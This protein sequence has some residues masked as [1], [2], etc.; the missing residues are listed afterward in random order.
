MVVDGTGFTS[1]QTFNW[2]ATQSHTISVDSIATGA[3]GTRHPYGSWSDG[4]ARSH[5][6]TPLTDSSF[7]AAMS[8]QYLL[9]MNAGT[10]GTVGP[11]N[12][13]FNAGQ[14]VQVSATPSA[15]YSFDAWT[16][17]GSGSFSGGTN[18][19]NVT[20]NAPVTETAAFTA[21][22]IVYTVTTNPA[23][24]DIIVDGVASTSPQAFNWTAAESHT[25]SVDSIQDGSAGTRYAYLSWSNAGTRTQ[26]ISPLAGG[27]LTASFRS[28]YFLT[29]A[30]N[31]GGTA[32]PSSNWQD[33][34]QVVQIT[35]IPN[36]GFIFSG[37]SG[38]GTGAF[39]GGT[40]PQS[41]TV[42]GPVTET[43]N[44]TLAP[45]QV[46]IQT[47]PSGRT[48]IVDG[49]TRTN[50]FTF[51]FNSGENHP[52]SADSIQTGAA[53][54]RYVW[55]SWSDGGTR[56]HT[57]TFPA[58]DTTIVVNLATQ[59]QLT[60]NSAIGGS[61]TPATGFY[62]SAQVVPIS[63]TPNPT[64]AFSAWSGTGAG[65]YSGPNNPAN[66]T[67]NAP[68]A[69][70]PSF[71]LAP[72][73]VTVQTS[74]AG[75]SFTV[76]GTSYV[77][78]Q[79]F[80]WSATSSHTIATT[81]PQGD[82]LT[83]Y[84]FA[85]W[86]DGGAIS[87]SVAPLTDTV[88]TV[89]FSTQYRLATI[90]GAN[91]T[92][93]PPTGFFNAGQVVA[94]NATPNSGYNFG[95]WTGTGAGSFTGAVAASNVTMNAPITETASFTAGTIPITV[96]TTPAGRTIIVDG[97]TLTSPQSFN[98]TT[99]SSHTISADSIQANG[100]PNVRYR[101]LSWS[102]AGAL[103]HT[104][105]PVA[106]TTY[107]AGFKTQ[108]QLTTI[109]NAGGTVTPPTG[110]FDSLAAVLITGIPN[111]GFIFS[112]WTGTG[113]GSYSG[114]TNP[115][116]ISIG[117]PVTETASFTPA[118]V[119]VTIQTNPS[120]RTFIVDGVTRTNS[121]AFVFNSGET[122]PISADSIQTGAAGTQYVWTS[123]SDG[124]NR[125]HTLAYP[126]KDTTIVVNFKTQFQLTMNSAANGSTSPA[127][128]FFDSAQVVPISATPNPTFVFAGW[129]GT[130]TGSYTGPNNPANVTMSAPVAE[131][132]SFASATVPITVTTTPAGRTII[133]DGTTLT[134]PQSFN[135]ATGSSHTISADSIQAGGA[136][137]ARYRW[138]SW[139]D[140]GALSHTVS[141]AAPT[142]YTAAFRTQY[143]L[144]TIAN[145]GGT[146]TPPTG[147][148]DSLA[149]VL[150]TGVPDSGFIFSAWTGTG[151]GSYSGTTNPR[152][153]NIG[154]PVTET[155]SFLPGPVQVT[156][157]TN[158][159]GRT[160]R[161]DGSTNFTNSSTFTFNSGDTH[162]ISA[163]SIQTGAAGT[164]YVWTSWS[165]GG[166]RVHA[167]AYPGKD[168]TIVVNLKTQFQLTMNSAVGGS[169]TPATGFFDSAQVVPI[170]GT[171][172][173]TF[174][175]SAWT[176]TGAGSY[177]GPN[178]P[179]NVTMN[180]P[181]AETPSFVLAPISVTVQSNPAGLSF[182]VDNLPY[183]GSQ[184]FVWSATSSHTI[185][186]TSPQGDTLTRY[187]FA[188]WS[189]GG[190]ISHTV[191]PIGDTVFTVN[192]S[193]QYRLAAIAGTNGTVTPPT[194]FFNAGQ[195]VAINATPNLGYNFGSWTG[196]GT[197]SFTGN[198]AA[199]N[200]TMDSPITETASF[201]AGT[202]P[203]TV[204]TAPAG[205]TIIV[206]GVTSTS[207][208]SF[209]WTTGSSHTIS[210]DSIQSSVTPG[211]RYRWLTWNDA[212]ALAHTVAPA[213]PTTYTAG[214][215]S[216][217]QLTTIANA[218][219]TVTPATG[220]YDSVAAVIIT[221]VP[222]SGYVFSTWAGTGTGSYSGG[223][224]PQTITIGG[225]VTETANFIQ[226]AVN[227]T[228]QTNPPGRTFRVD[229]GTLQSNT[230]TFS[231]SPGTTH[232]VAADSIQTGATGIRYVWTSWSDGEARSH[233]LVY[234]GRDTTIV[235]NFK[236]Q[237]QLTMNSVANGN[238]SP[239]TGFFDSAQVV[240]ITA[241]PA[242]GFAFTGWTGTGSQPGFY[243]G[244]DNP[245]S[246][247][248]NSP[249]SET[250]SFSLAP[251]D[252]VVLSNPRG[253]QFLV[254][255]T[256]YADSQAFV[257]SA[258]SPHTIATTSPQGDT[259]TRFLYSSWS[260]GGAVSHTVA[261][262]GD[263]VFTVNFSTQYRL[264]TI[265]GTGGTVTPPTGFFNVGQIVAI[266]AIPNTGYD[267]E[268]W[269][270]TGTGS[271][272]GNVAAS[273]VTMNAPITETASFTAGTIPIT[274]TTAP[275]GRT[276]IV[277]GTIYTGPQS[278]N[279]AT[280]SSHTIS[281]D[282][283]QSSVTP[284]LRYRWLTWSD[285]GALA[286]T[287][288]PV[289]PT[290]YTAGFKSQYQLTTAA[291][292]GGTVTPPTGF[293]DSLAAVLITGVP[294]SG[295]V[296]ATWAGTGTG[297][298]SGGNN[299][300]TITIGGPVTETANF[301]QPAVN[302]TIQTNPAGR[303]FRVDGGGLL[304]NTYTFSF[305]PGT[306]HTVSAD[307]IQNGA[308]GIRSVWTSWSDG[309]DRVHT[310]V[311]PGKDTTIVVNF[312]TQF[313]LTMNSVAN[314]NTS[315]A[316][317]FFDSAQ[318]VGITATP[319]GG[320]AF[321]GW[322]GTGSQPGFYTGPD[323][324]ASVTMNSPVS[325]TPSFS[326]APINVTVQSNPAG[327]SFTVDNVPYTGSQAFV[328]S[329]T[330]SHT[331]ATTSPQGDTATRFLF[332]NWSDGKA[333]SHQV[334]PLT[335]SVFTVNFS[336]QYFVTMDTGTGFGSVAPASGF[337]NAG[338][339]VGITATADP[340]FTFGGWT[341]TGTGSY[342]GPNNPGTI[343]VDGP[344]RETS[345]WTAGTIPVT[346]ATVPAGLAITVDG[347]DYTGPQSFNWTTGSSHSIGTDSIQN[348]GVP[349][350]RNR[351]IAWSDAGTLS[352]VV[353]PTSATT[354]TA[355]FRPQYVLTMT[356]NP[357]GTVA[358]SSGGYYD[359]A[360]SV[361]ITA[362]SSSGYSFAS[363]SGTGQGAY[364]GNANPTNISVRG[365][366]TET[367]N[368]AQVA[369]QVT[370]Q[371]NPPGRTFRVDGGGLLTNTYTFTYAP[372]DAPHSLSADSIQGVTAA[373]RYVWT[374]WS[375]GGARAHTLPFPGKDTT[376]VVNFKRQFYLT[377]TAGTGG[378]VQ[379]ASG[380]FDTAQ[381]VQIQATPTGGYAF[382]GWTGN[383]RGS[384]TGPNNPGTV[385]MDTAIT[386]SGA[387][388]LAPI[389]VI[390]RTNPR[391]LQFI[392]DGAAYADSQAFVWSATSPHTL[393]ATSPQGD[394]ATRF[395]FGAWSDGGAQTHSVAPVGDSIFTVNFTTQHYLAMDTGT[396]GG[397]LSP[398]SGFFNAGQAVQVSATPR[399]G[400]NFAGWTGTGSGS[401]S[402]ANNPAT[403]TMNAPLRET[404]GWS[405]GTI[406]VT[407]T[408]LPA[409][410][411]MTVD[412][413]GYTSP[414]T[415]NWTTGSSHSISTDSVQSAGAAGTRY[416][417]ASWSDAG[418]LTHTVTP[419]GP[420][421][422]TATFATQYFVTMTAN[423]GGTVT[424]SS[425]W[426]DAAGNVTI[427][428]VPNSGF[429]F[430]GWIGSGSGSYTGSTNPRVIV[431]NGPITQVA[432]FLQNPFTV[433]VQT[434]PPG[435]T[436]RANGTTYTTQQTFS[437]S[438]GTSISLSIPDTIQTNGPSMRYAWRT[439]SNGGAVSHLFMPTSDTTITAGF[440]TQFL[441][442][443]S[444][445]SG[446]AV[447]PASGWHDSASTVQVTAT[448]SGGY[449][450]AG[451]LGTGAG[452][453]SGPLNPATVSVNAPVSESGS[454]TL[455]PV[456]V[457]LRSNPPG[458]TVLVDSIPYVT[459]QDIIWTSGTSHTLSAD[460][461]QGG[462]TGV[463]YLYTGW[464]DGKAR[465]HSVTGLGDTTFTV[466]F[467]SQYFLT[468]DAGVG[469][470]ALPPDGWYDSAASVPITATPATGYVFSDWSGS[471]TGAY[472][473]P[474][475][476]SAV[477]MQ[478]PV[479]ELANFIL[480]TVQVSVRTSPDGYPVYVDG[481]Q[482]TSPANF[483]W[484][485]GSNHTV[486]T[487]SAQP[488][489][490]GTR[491][492]WLSW[493]DAGA[494]THAVAPM[495]DSTFTATLGLQYLVTMVAN[496]GGTVSPATGW[497][498]SGA[499]VTITATPNL[500][501]A[502]ASWSGGGTGSYSGTT[503]PRPITVGGPISQT[504]NFSQN[505]ILV[506]VQTDPPGRTFRVDG[507]SYTTVNTFSFLPGTSHAFTA[508]S[509][510]PGTGGTRYAWTG[511]STGAPRTHNFT[512]PAK[513]ST[514]SVSFGLQWELLTVANP[515][516]GGTIN[517]PGQS[518]YNAGDTATVL[519]N[520]NRGYA[521]T[522]WSG[523]VVSSANPL[524]V[525]MDSA[526]VLNAHF[527]VASNVII[528]SNPPGRT[529]TVD[530]FAFVAPDT[531]SWLLNST[532]T[533]GSV[534]PQSGSTATR[535]VFGNW[536][537]SG[538]MSHTVTVGRD[539]TFT[540]SFHTQYYLMVSTDSNGSVSP[541]P[542]WHN[543]GDS[544]TL[545][546]TPNTGYGFIGWTGS[547]PAG[548][549]GYSNPV[550]LTMNDWAQEGASFGQI[551]PPP[552]LTWLPNHSVDQ[553]IAPRLCW[554]HYAG[555]DN[556][557]VQVSTDSLFSP[558]S[559][560][561]DSAGIADTT[562]LVP[563]LKNVQTY[564]WRVKA[565][566]GSD[567]T[568]F[569]DRWDFSTVGA[570]IEVT[571]PALNW[572]TGFTYDIAW[573]SQNLSGTVNVLLSTNGGTNWTPVDTETADTTTRFRVAT[574]QQVSNFCI[575][576]VVSSENSQFFGDS[577]SFAILP[578]ALPLLTPVS[579][580]I[581][582]PAEPTIST[583]YRLVSHPGVVD[584]T[585]KLDAMIPGS[586]P[587]DWRMF[588]D[589]GR[590][591]NY[592]TE[593]GANSTLETG[594]GYWML[595]R[596]DW[597]ISANML[598]PPLDTV[599]AVYR[600][601][602]RSGWNI[603]ANP[604]DRNA[605]WSS[606]VAL[607]DLPPTTPL[608]SY[609]G[610]YEEATL[611]APFRGYYFYNAG[612][613]PELEIAYPF[614]TAIPVTVARDVEWEVRLEY[615]SE[616]N[617]D[618]VNFIGVAKASA[619]GIDAMET[620]KPPVFL[621]QGFLYFN[622][623]E[624][625]AEYSLF[626][627]DF[628]PSI[629]EGQTWDFEV[630]REYGTTGTL[631]FDGIDRIPAGYEAVLVNGYNSA[632]V[633]L[634]K[635]PEYHF[636]SVSTKMP[637][638]LLVGPA[639]YVKREVAAEVPEEFGLDQNFPNPF[640][641]TTS[642]S[643]KLPHDS[644]I[645]LDVYDVLGRRVATLADGDYAGGTH[646]FL[647]EGLDDRGLPVS[648]GIYLYRLVEGDRMVQA[649]K[650][651]IAK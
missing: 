576:R 27:T 446:G 388:T 387:F 168:T 418:A 5:T 243:T 251:I 331:I 583:F 628:R 495:K 525:V 17:T 589:N 38:S 353:A 555:A 445:G 343:T 72:I 640:N 324:P 182:T 305:S 359:S 41:I 499:S 626:N 170:T 92:V 19:V 129:A 316:T 132:P 257:W 199:S 113:T 428:G 513:D 66:V 349:G 193:T 94:I 416:R 317:G 174:A 650:M 154:G 189:D 239:A 584:S 16:G 471:G 341:G 149:A 59:F 458:R 472:T 546:A 586:N 282:S 467:R 74:P 572:G 101:W 354:F 125:V 489:S 163:D 623:P 382:A 345:A 385:S 40:N 638:K 410:L 153:I 244:P 391:G 221:G 236:T 10:G 646:T 562:I 379:P 603:I 548:Y 46:T 558:R 314:G 235:V 228:I 516:A 54:T 560:I 241:T 152:S 386:Q 179:A 76:D 233:T 383:G 248:M 172:N 563:A 397:T 440:A 278:F 498:N 505:T 325:E 530:G 110:Y 602:L 600:I 234:P 507:T 622:R 307:S 276:I 371:T 578:G 549:T 292:P 339:S 384:Y 624:W 336:T 450:F 155:A 352:H 529:L 408:T 569:S 457:R 192:F 396:G 158:P 447:S 205:R 332:Q 611:L 533:L 14:S 536:S 213:A 427:T 53:G 561:V 594:R 266:N 609:E 80:V 392:V 51:A 50:S 402:G 565:M 571:S 559:N 211:L 551:L 160:F 370:I 197:G 501:F 477:T 644:K 159:P 62:D 538:A 545:F 312:K 633:D 203:I 120:G 478:G 256:T 405:A 146:V 318:V 590:P 610:S 204:T 69:E 524:T 297:S 258:T 413:T 299:P 131:T 514:L 298:Y 107:T 417:W 376:I 619:E 117:G 78:S 350:T 288:A 141:P 403:V 82:T 535:Y 547:G 279:W 148:Y 135:W 639:E 582:F 43:A 480:D 106:P 20:M 56:A 42:R 613:L 365:P 401:Y 483:N 252:V 504:A 540:A 232:T 284:G 319:T 568:A 351:W 618:P 268:S 25:V 344:I 346:V 459:P 348:S 631:K 368:F 604:F 304:S 506:T 367:A 335:D 526:R 75:R 612:N 238:T 133:V 511:W 407:V 237:F 200:V 206:D 554:N 223:T 338:Q 567:I 184:A 308:T 166:A 60:M 289:A 88:F 165:D 474:L 637:F 33:S 61:T 309:G 121:F 3:A 596:N 108:Y 395:L 209:N 260:D 580:T 404:A 625:D 273:N 225:P 136:P 286:H 77:G 620:H 6:V 255:G 44:F 528:A 28:Q 381:A 55:N 333:I 642:I 301:T 150:I 500:G 188:N 448:P 24:L 275:A 271:F 207:P 186:T 91:G 399:S 294:N 337:F 219:G 494:R 214:F 334:A 444:A 83:R 330:S 18:P 485:A 99:G 164:R 98:W 649:R 509:L 465:T 419:G 190:A 340:G 601:R 216:Q 140:A 466:S 67:M 310:L 242:G 496:P 481:V 573:R 327:R 58:Q 176:G 435:R 636:S 87:H 151:T 502:F 541:A 566:V 651:I 259:L 415:F 217:Y 262:L 493:N 449:T 364:S 389:D 490:G 423:P 607:N 283:I 147:F 355:T 30:A 643:V 169:A 375:D 272:T 100:A 70:T 357:G 173:P 421:T 139:S 627:T 218:G 432:N 156:I 323:N 84:L 161:I 544:V 434:S 1:P 36:S 542:D 534:T 126:G 210:S 23:G 137:D 424:P 442:S 295:Y 202:I 588:S 592:L 429:S 461:L 240:G 531:F 32:T 597:F 537:D 124:G 187:L 593:L 215:K 253:R 281:S 630:T 114:G 180:A 372:G 250:P 71:I 406:P 277:D 579:T 143:Q 93:T 492:G 303:T 85:N 464:N 473:G 519:A 269:T 587:K 109:A 606:I 484:L 412:G 394:T 487:D 64:F 321:T 226:P 414:Q 313:Q 178:N 486:S 142:T 224:N 45:V 249:V 510:Q 229:N 378:S 632:P 482:F 130:G 111:S 208:Q 231:F 363:W 570:M 49:V 34:A 575:I 52:I 358:P 508:D 491:L 585:I 47:N 306:T 390:V 614:G 322:T 347:V 441:L 361:Q 7:T 57:L 362:I 426:F 37:W 196:T 39:S 436:F 366:V 515:L 454:F 409:G 520:S 532:H 374:S 377:A 451:W 452:S 479:G 122:H 267:F 157:Q 86:S 645:R 468:M 328:W 634:R 320:F 222:N 453:Y 527:Q 591:E 134:S 138:L 431:A 356:A 543:A 635:N 63:A 65:S 574:T 422:L 4:G 373:S 68:V 641:S 112:G 462:A 326:L 264:A 300:Q 517:P 512:A 270:G 438:P 617:D 191:A 31:A 315:P 621:D 145:T 194:G 393:S 171:P 167:L 287:V 144:T 48:F 564:Y 261:P 118:P 497:A 79:A 503:N 201:T 181:V 648:S 97:T 247:A 557:I 26:T 437:V 439:W 12:A 629:G 263:T 599:N 11:A 360:Q 265:A 96:N 15:G 595:K 123:W 400:Y 293:Y 212:G 21:N 552:S 380:F 2:T 103:S 522:S 433:V 556:Y 183:T 274:V 104:V 605:S 430:T 128:G 105:A 254:D 296:F 227:V 175:F 195:V 302:V 95:T 581:T 220:Y 285:A 246:V 460:S 518:Y 185:A 443:M 420:V 488:P 469:G 81:S 280:G 476:P 290:T 230:Y 615:S 177:S 577:R 521:F 398:A 475:N 550:T 463:R 411:A 342:T 329:A 29:M 35:G 608:Y 456:T 89:N 13:F 8:T 470:T 162:S 291:N 245:A 102:D 127:T 73:D 553:P 116:T 198:V 311:Y 22:P 425:G 455:F 90:A 9:T 616:L 647:W 523:S 115:Q 369:V 598:L 119:Q 539:T